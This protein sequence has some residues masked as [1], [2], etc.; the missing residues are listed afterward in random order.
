M[1]WL[2]D[3]HDYEYQF[4]PLLL[5]LSITSAAVPPEIIGLDIVF[6]HAIGTNALPKRNYCIAK[7]T[8]RC[9]CTAICLGCYYQQH[10]AE[11]NELLKHV[12]QAYQDFLQ[13]GSILY[14]GITFAK[15]RIHSPKRK[16]SIQWKSC[17]SFSLL[18]I[19]RW[20]WERT[21]EDPIL[22][23]TLGSKI[24]DV[25]YYWG[26]A[27]STYGYHTMIFSDE[28]LRMKRDNNK[29]KYGYVS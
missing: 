5:L 19:L 7:G 27:P 21:I 13:V 26:A 6:F 16:C 18:K 1:W 12:R 28:F 29:N 9:S 11:K 15:C 8:C 25:H 3:L 24:N 2:Y 22:I 10:M 14:C 20:H 4:W 23:E 17:R